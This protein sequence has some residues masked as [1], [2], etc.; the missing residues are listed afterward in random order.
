MIDYK[1]E[2]LQHDPTLDLD[3]K[4]EFEIIDMFA[5]M[6]QQQYD[7]MMIATTL[8]EKF[9]EF[10]DNSQFGKPERMDVFAD[11]FNYHVP[12]ID[13]ASWDIFLDKCGKYSSYKKARAGILE[14]V[15][16]EYVIFTRDLETVTPNNIRNLVS[17]WSF[18]LSGDD[19]KKITNNLLGYLK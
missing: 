8:S 1:E 19:S 15:F 12:E 14:E 10:F 13:S 18:F 5:K 7:G 16:T 6:K 2:L 3:S 17:G 9:R 4:S 11:I